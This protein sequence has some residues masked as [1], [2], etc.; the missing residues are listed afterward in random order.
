MQPPPDAHLPPPPPTVSPC[1]EQSRCRVGQISGTYGWWGPRPVFVTAL[2]HC[3]TAN[4]LPGLHLVTYQQ[5]RNDSQPDKVGAPCSPPLPEGPPGSRRGGPGGSCP[6][7][8]Q[9]SIVRS[10]TIT[11][12]PSGDTD[13][14]LVY[15]GFIYPL[16]GPP[17]VPGPGPSV[18]ARIQRLYVVARLGRHPNSPELVTG[19]SGGRPGGSGSLLAGGGGIMGFGRGSWAGLGSSPCRKR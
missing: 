3:R 12:S 5:P 19:C 6:P 1:P 11:L 17:L 14:S 7:H 4:F 13:V 18:W 9:V 16:L 15:R 8:P 10:T 2:Q